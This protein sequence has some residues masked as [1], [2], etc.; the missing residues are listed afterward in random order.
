MTYGELLKY[1]NGC[2][3]PE[4]TTRLGEAS[5]SDTTLASMEGKTSML[6]HLTVK[7][8][9]RSYQGC[10]PIL[11]AASPDGAD[12]GGAPTFAGIDRPT[13]KVSATA[14]LIAAN[15]VATVILWRERTDCPGMSLNARMRSKGLRQGARK[16]TVHETTHVRATSTRWRSRDIMER[17]GTAN[18]APRVPDAAPQSCGRGPPRTC[19][20]AH[21][22]SRL[23]RQHRRAARDCTGVLRI[24]VINASF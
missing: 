23:I 20:S 22:A 6:N 12:R 8:S 11:S 14:A 5:W 21:S 1:R 19:A 15:A 18:R 9:C 24:S 17:A 10:G 4:L 2:S 3:W 16:Q 13:H 7:K